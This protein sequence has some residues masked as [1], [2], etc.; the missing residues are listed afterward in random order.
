MCP[1]PETEP[2]PLILVIPRPTINCHSI[3]R[4][5]QKAFPNSVQYGRHRAGGNRSHSGL[6]PAP[7][8]RNGRGLPQAAAQHPSPAD[9]PPPRLRI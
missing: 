7:R 9:T 8:R 5:G 1:S 6:S 2:P 3:L 4:Y